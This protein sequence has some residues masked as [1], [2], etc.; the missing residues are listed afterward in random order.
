MNGFLGTNEEKVLYDLMKE[1]TEAAMANGN[2]TQIKE[3]INWDASKDFLKLDG[4]FLQNE[5][6]SPHITCDQL[7]G[8]VLFLIDQMS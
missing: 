3:N 2:K 7:V 8:F 4:N 6:P 5:T 1:K